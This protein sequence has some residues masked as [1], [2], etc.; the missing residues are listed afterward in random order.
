LVLTVDA[1]GSEM[2]SGEEATMSDLR[3]V[4]MSGPLTRYVDGFCD[5]LAG[6]G[7]AQH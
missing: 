1:S 7:Y 5:E 2:D 6:Q 4:R 3:A